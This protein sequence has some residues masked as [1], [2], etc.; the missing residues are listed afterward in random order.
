[1]TKTITMRQRLGQ[2]TTPHDQYSGGGSMP[3]TYHSMT[4]NTE[5]GAILGILELKDATRFYI[6]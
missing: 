6:Y 5:K 3:E 4:S 2:A 1:M